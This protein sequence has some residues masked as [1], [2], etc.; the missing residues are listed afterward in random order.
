MPLS[1]VVRWGFV[2]GRVVREN[3][4]VDDQSQ[5]RMARNEALFREANEAILTGVWPG[6]ETKRVRFR[7]ECGRPECNEMVELTVGEY[8]QVRRHPRRFVLVKGHEI[9]EIEAVVDS[10]PGGVVVQKFGTAG[11]EAEARDPRS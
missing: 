3:A 1:R 2:S 9:P 4:G 8:E 10:N 7:C 11:D 5:E 6:E